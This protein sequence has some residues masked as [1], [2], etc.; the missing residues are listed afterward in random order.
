MMQCEFCGEQFS[1]RDCENGLEAGEFYRP[2]DGRLAI[3]HVDCLPGDGLDG[4]DEG[5]HLA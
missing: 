5:W 1:L 4:G 2:A 3:A